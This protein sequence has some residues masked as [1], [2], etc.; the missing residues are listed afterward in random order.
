MDQRLGPSWLLLLRDDS[1]PQAPAVRVERAR[2]HLE[3]RGSAPLQRRN[4][5]LAEADGGEGGGEVAWREGA[6]AED[7]PAAVVLDRGDVDHGRG[8]AGQLA[9][10]DR[11]VDGGED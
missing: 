11:Q 6:L 9:A 2:Q 8:Q 10:V 3:P 5:L 1:R 7:L 4:G